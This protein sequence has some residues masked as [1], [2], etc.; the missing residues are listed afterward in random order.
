[1]SWKRY[2]SEINFTIENKGPIHIGA[3]DEE[4]L[5]DQET[6]HAIIPGTS[7]AGALR[8]YLENVQEHSLVARL[9]GQQRTEL[10]GDKSSIKVSDLYNISRSQEKINIEYRPAIRVDR[11]YGTAKQ[12]FERM[13]V[14]GGV[15]FSGKLI[16]TSDHEEEQKKFDEM[17]FQAL[18]ALHLGVIR[19]GAYKTSGGGRIELKHAEI[20]KVDLYNSHHLFSYFLNSDTKGESGWKDI[21]ELLTNMSTGSS[22]VFRLRAGLNTPLLIKGKSVWQEDLPNSLPIQLADG[23]YFVP[24]S[25][26]KGALRQQVERIAAYLNKTELVELAFGKLGT[27]NRSTEEHHASGVL[28]FSDAIIQSSDQ[29]SHIDYNMI[30]INKLTGGVFNGAL[31]KERT[32]HGEVELE[33]TFPVINRVEQHKEAISGLLL[34]ALRD[35]AEQGFAL[36]SGNSKGRGALK[37]SILNIYTPDDTITIDFNHDKT[38]NIDLANEWLRALHEWNQK[39][40][41]TITT[42]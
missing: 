1:M 21:R 40:I 29:S 11:F 19:L 32:V 10:N 33:L 25:S 5:V 30:H 2:V 41:S 28:Q 34:L 38:V 9:F 42:S 7:F 16:W 13:F 18:S 39:S 35:L 15:E 27:D 20:R 24:G 6:N 12:K 22:Y 4:I 23:K 17:M 3:Q 26:W 14:A 37:G 31:V 36:G 8:S